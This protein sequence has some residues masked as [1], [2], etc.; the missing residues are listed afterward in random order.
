MYDSVKIMATEYVESL[1]HCF[2]CFKHCHDPRVLKCFHEFCLNCLEKKVKIRSGQR[3][4]SCPTCKRATRLP[5][6][7]MVTDLPQQVANITIDT[8]VTDVEQISGTIDIAGEFGVSKVAVVSDGATEADGTNTGVSPELSDDKDG[9]EFTDGTKVTDGDYAI[10]DSSDA[11]GITDTSSSPEG[12]NVTNITDRTGANNLTD[13]FNDFDDFDVANVTDTADGSDGSDAIAVANDDN[14][15]SFVDRALNEFSQA[16]RTGANNVTD[17]FDYSDDDFDVINVTDTADGSD[18]S[19]AT[20]VANDDNMLPFVDHAF[21]EIPQA[22]K[23]LL[24]PDTPDIR[25]L[26]I[27]CDH[28]REKDG[29]A[30]RYC[31]DCRD[32]LCVTCYG[33][34][35]DVP[36]LAKHKS[37]D[38]VSSLFCGKHMK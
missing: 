35:Q 22:I 2:V 31:Y 9:T 36:R 8:G 10:N 24:T 32:H 30:A 18:G 37:T 21:N 25:K 34:H 6:G 14:M 28:C 29:M 1:V 33:D 11:V 4:I 38:I 15:L 3:R 26:S 7:S 13:Y 17:D 5:E 12:S 16:I 27:N 20:A 19:D 23:N